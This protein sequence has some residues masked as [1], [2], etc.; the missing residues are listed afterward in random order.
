MATTK[1]DQVSSLYSELKK[2]TDEY[3]DEHS[4][5]IC[6]SIIQLDPDDQVALQCKVVTLI[7]LDKYTEAL[8]LI[9]R[10]F[11]KSDIDLSF[12]KLYCYYRTNQLQPALELLNEL[13]KIKKDDVGLQ[14]MEAQLLYAQD[15]YEASIKVYEQLL[16]TTNK[17][18]RLYEEIQVNLLAAK[19]GLLFAN[20]KAKDNVKEPLYD[21]SAPG[22]YEVAYNAASV[23]LAR[24]ELDLARE[25]L[26]FARKQCNERMTEAGLSH[27]EIDEELAVIAAQLAYTH[28]LQGRT[29]EAKELYE[30]VLNSKAT[31][32]GVT[33]IVSNNVVA[34][35]ETKDLFDAAKKLK[36]ATSKEAEAK[37][38]RYQKRVIAMNES[39][40]QLYM[41]KHA[42]CR[43]SAQRLIA[44]YPDSDTLYLIL[45][46]A[47]YHQSKGEKAVE[48]LKKYAEKKPES[49][50]IRFAT[51]QLQLLQS[52]PADALSTLESY[53]KVIDEKDQ[54]G[55]YQP[56]V[57]AL[58]VWL[59][60][61]TNQSE[62]AME[63]LDKASSLWKSDSS[64]LKSAPA[65]IIK[66]TAAFKL[67]T[68][69]YSEAASD[70]EQ[71]VKADP[72]DSQ[73]IAGL[74]SAYAE[75]DPAKAEQY[76]DAL[77]AISMHHIDVDTLERI[78]PGVKRGYVKKDPKSTHVKK[79]KP[80][81]KRQPLLP[82]N[83]DL[84]RTPDPERWLPKRERS[85]YRA[86]GKNK[87]AALRGPQ[88]SAVEGGGIGGTGSAN[89]GGRGAPVVLEKEV[90]EK[91]QTVPSAAPKAAAN[92]KKTKKKGGKS[93]W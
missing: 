40:L 56:G 67:K 84:S 33:A 9:T 54:K 31:D 58:L 36:V 34:M 1:E 93:K 65:S 39:L 29:E 45:A 49:L 66:Q 51:I 15:N 90:A 73:A 85:T 8:S 77:P 55:F 52:Q 83:C 74:I 23:H 16:K 38:K 37:L 70:Y 44:K 35:Q 82:K 2:S 21:I 6:D 75:V 47:T 5:S 62:K 22:A 81:K 43:D 88:G 10:K 79:V 26:E 24:S 59:Y 4:L 92:K 17:N 46:A 48:E 64:F 42:A 69:R 60:E 89:I 68:G 18:D 91:P 86:K 72:T 71:L 57:V 63:T 11:K 14:Y 20:P 50:A 13:K 76:G 30:S 7:R 3:D 80:K 25:Q 87:K 78:V 61:Q 12:E 32:A 27:E 53:L 41:N 28:Q 19:A